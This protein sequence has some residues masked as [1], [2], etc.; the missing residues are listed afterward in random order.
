MQ[1]LLPQSKIQKESLTPIKADWIC[2]KKIFSF[3]LDMNSW[4]RRRCIVWLKTQLLLIIT[5]HQAIPGKH[6]S[7]YKKGC[8]KYVGLGI[9]TLLISLKYLVYFLINLSFGITS[10]VARIF[11]TRLT[12]Q[13]RECLNCGFRA[14][15]ALMNMRTHEITWEVESGCWGSQHRAS[16]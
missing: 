12:V 8:M 14:K 1:L 4:H 16:V 13:L 11:D 10:I 2:M 7:Q 5:L 9:V 6:Q 15:S 3:V